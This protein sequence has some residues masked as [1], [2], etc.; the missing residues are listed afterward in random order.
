[1]DIQT[2]LKENGKAVVEL[3]ADDLVIIC[4]VFS[5]QL[6]ENRHQDAFMQL[7]GDMV[8]ARD[9]CQFGHVDNSCLQ[10]IVKCRDG[11]KGLFPEESV[12]A[13][14]DN[15]KPSDIRQYSLGV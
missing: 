15:D 5:A 1:M 3:T 8:M 14:S 6:V 2:I 10:Y 11:L 4:N 9:L 13:S 7:Y 12:Q